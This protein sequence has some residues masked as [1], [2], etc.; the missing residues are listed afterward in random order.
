MPWDLAG[1]ALCIHPLPTS[2]IFPL[3]IA[4]DGPLVSPPSPACK[5]VVLHTALHPLSP[6]S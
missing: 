3:P 6:A 2:G 1:V 4:A 5:G